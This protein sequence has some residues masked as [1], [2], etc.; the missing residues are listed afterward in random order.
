MN[1]YLIID[2]SSIL[3]RAFYA[4][5][6][7]NTKDGKYTNAVVGFMNILLKAIEL[8][9]P[10]N[11]AVCFD[12]KDKTFRSEMYGDY[13]A[14][15]TSAPEELSHQFGY[16]K[17]I[18]NSYGINYFELSG[19]EADDIAGTLSKD[20]SEKG[21]QVF[22]LS[23]DKDYMQLI[24]ENTVFLYTKTGISDIKRYDMET[25]KEELNLTPEQIID[26]KGL[27]GDKS[28]NI[29]GI[30]GVGEKTA[31]KLLYEYG[32]VENL[33]ENTDNLP[34]N[35][36]NQKII[37]NEEIA[38]LSKSLA[39]IDRDVPIDLENIDTTISEFDESTLLEVLNKYEMN[40]IIKRLGLSENIK[41]ESKPSKIIE[42]IENNDIYEIINILS[43]ESKFSFKI[44]SSDKPYNEIKF[45]KIAIGID[46][47][48]Y[49]NNITEKDLLEFKEIFESEKILKFGSDIK[50][51]IMILMSLGIDIQ[52]C[53]HD[54]NIAEYLLNPTDTDYSN[55]KLSV[56]YNVEFDQNYPD[57]KLFK[58]HIND[59][60]EIN[61][62]SYLKNTI[63]LV[64][65]IS[66]IQLD[67]LK[68]EDMLN[69]YEEIEMPLTKVLADMELTGV[70][71]D[72]DELSRIGKNLDSE[73]EVLIN[74]IYSHAGEE[75]NINSPKQLSEIL[76]EK[77]E[78]PPI[79]KTKT[80]YSTNIDVLEKLES[81]H[82][83]ISYI[84]RYRTISKL[85]STYVDG[86]KEF[87]NKKTGRIHSNFKQ[88]VAATGRLSSTDP[89]LQNIPVKTDEGRELRK[90]FKSQS[91]EYKLVDADYSQ[92]ELRLLADISNDENM[93]NSFIEKIDIHST[94]ASKVFDV[95]LD[96]ITSLMRSRAKAV[97]FGIV[98]GVSDYG[99][100][101]NLNI[102][103]KEAKNY[104]DNYLNEFSGVKKYMEDIV[105]T[106]K[107]NEFVS[108]KFGR[109]RY[110]PELK[111][112]NNNVRGFGERIA[113][114]MPIQGTAADI[115]KIAMI[116][117]YNKLKKNNLKS[118]LILQIHDELIIEA[119][120]SEVEI[121]KDILK[122]EM[123]NAVDLTVPLTVDLEVGE[124][125]Y[126][127]K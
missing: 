15:R 47:K 35:K 63:N 8:I 88:N 126:D 103:R 107:E 13:K 73:L 85:K 96:E 98:Y 62:I 41:K 102:T 26:L 86:L 77:L 78:L 49:I 46:S 69:L 29:P 20:G 5:P 118:K 11:V 59:W 43:K 58:K 24:D 10:T 6:S 89:N 82:E 104:I 66:Q 3:F 50:D 87:I 65:E 14:N 97:N 120:N 95:D 116:N 45:E 53:Y 44:L 21:S 110:L 7:M 112:K 125:W 123:E 36:T 100:S 101:Q 72:S 64:D 92:I 84:I 4:V 52:G 121:I 79:K 17:E 109:K 34:K 32:S 60:E 19:Y 12:L 91:D 124:S 106:A 122:T 33:Y 55:D 105:E 119:P 40:S 75:F 71:V 2:G 27:M 18:L 31:L 57:K 111:S 23:G 22:L 113:L 127:T 56:T 61:K 67:K 38:K 114:N 25:L 83:I 80:G 1:K 9:E 93:L 81:K 115:I 70:Y 76:F 51:D 30:P 16:I 99:L 48:I 108:T 74:E 28:D 54:I 37:D 117:V 94:T 39:K 42:I 68:E 90:I